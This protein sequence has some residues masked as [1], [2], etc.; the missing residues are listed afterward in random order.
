MFVCGPLSLYV[1]C[2]QVPSEVKGMYCIPGIRA[3]NSELSD[4]GFGN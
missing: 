4:V 2:V 3:T 1:M